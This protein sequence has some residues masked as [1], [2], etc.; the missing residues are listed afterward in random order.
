MNKTTVPIRGMHCRSCEILIEDE[1]KHVP[2]VSKVN[3]SAKKGLAEVFHTQANIDSHA[4]SK[5]VQNAGYE[6]GR[7]EKR[8]W[9]TRDSEIYEQIVASASIL[10]IGAFVL[11][12]FGFFNN[13]MAHQTSSASLPV[14]FI[15]GLTAGISTCMAL[16]GGLVLSVASRFSQKHPEATPVQK[17]KPQLMFN[18]GR[19]ASYFIFGALIGWAGSFL[20]LSS[21]F[22][23]ILSIF[24][25]L[26][27]VMLGIQ[28][29][30]ISPRLSAFNFT[31]PKGIANAL[32]VTQK[33]DN[34]YSNRGA[35]TLGALTFFLP[36]GFTQAMQLYAIST[37][38]PLQGSL[39]MG[40]FALGTAPGL[41]GIGTLTSFIKGAFAQKFFKFAGVLVIALAFVNMS[42]ALN[43]LGVTSASVPQVQGAQTTAKSGSN[44]ESA[45]AEMQNGEQIIKATYTLSGGMQ[46]KVLTAKAG[47]PTKLV[48]DV[49]EDGVG[50]MSTM[51]IPGLDG[52]ARFLKGGSK[53]TFSF[54]PQTKTYNITCA[55]GLPHGSLQVSS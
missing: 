12:Y 53:L 37:G 48:V 15:I 7:G 22:V 43:L 52:K 47:I 49:K 16:V 4:I 45:K 32:G 33:K 44:S 40:I 31:L 50:C 3:V 36:C 10:V 18:L 38:S 14:V 8:P 23:G 17:L 28:L 55:M 42:S 39:I 24:V 21:S 1:L 11:N 41:V 2:G 26:V 29:T 54:T 13:S 27:M 9:F 6:V 30:G 35:M 51:L 20:Q 46:P 5:A 25:A 34:E 19:I